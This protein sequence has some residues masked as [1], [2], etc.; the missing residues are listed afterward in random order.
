MESA[1]VIRS[2]IAI[3]FLIILHAYFTRFVEMYVTGRRKRFR[4]H[5]VYIFFIRINITP[6]VFFAIFF[7][8]LFFLIFVFHTR[9]IC[10]FF[11]YI[12][13]KLLLFACHLNYE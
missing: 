6:I 8:F 12:A 9:V 13:Q 2:S 1:L 5:K 10:N 3:S 11:N 7:A 4:P